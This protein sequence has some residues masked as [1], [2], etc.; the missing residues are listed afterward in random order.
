MT[1]RVPSQFLAAVL[2]LPLV[3]AGC[4]ARDIGG[5]TAPAGAEGAGILTLPSG[6]SYSVFPD[7]LAYTGNATFRWPD[8]RQYE[9][10]FAQG[11]AQ[12]MGS[13]SWPNGDVYRGTWQAGQH[14]G[15]GELTRGDDS[16]YVGD[17]VEGQR[18]GSGVEQSSEG[19]Y[20][21][22]WRA[23]LPNGQGEFHGTD[24]ASYK[25]QWYDGSRQG[26]G[27]YT[28]TDGNRYEGDWYAD[29]PEGFGIMT[30]TNGSVYE[31]EWRA[32][33]Q[34]GY[35]KMT[36]DSGAVYEGT[37]VDG[38][39][40][41]FGIARRPDGSRYDGEWV[42]GQRAGQ[43]RESFPDGSFHEGMWLADRPHGSGIR[44]DRTGIVIGGEWDGDALNFGRLT[45]PSGAEYEGGLLVRNNRAVNAQLLEWLES[46]SAGDDAWAHFFLGTAYSDFADPAPDRFKATGHFR[47]AARAGIADGQFRLGLLLAERAP[48]EALD[49]LMKAAAQNQAQANTLLG[50]YYLTGHQVTADLDLAIAFLTAGSEA[51]DMTARNNLAWVLATTGADEYRDPE[52]SLALIRPIA[53]MHGGWQHYDTLAAAYAAAG[54]FDDAERTQQAA[55]REASETLGEQSPEVTAMQVRLETYQSGT[56]IRE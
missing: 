13:G 10:Q 6:R 2:I 15:H 51:G 26:F 40:Q 20:R 17:F 3:L 42:A 49:W 53:L 39:R 27:L 5:P 54:R 50:E 7:E 43:G 47:A 16:R 21:G 45:L 22:D 37:W 18:E 1:I 29:V 28:D 44:Q 32:S 31:G 23:D 19:L 24:G 55:I 25:G 11:R 56:P 34:N 35:G 12:G 14:H 38:D 9:G 8:G 36:A 41:G 48:E 46:T 4:A 52:A 33:Q 30:N